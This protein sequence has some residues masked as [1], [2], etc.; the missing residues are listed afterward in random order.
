MSDT[1]KIRIYIG[2]GIV[3]STREIEIEED[4]GIWERM[5]EKERTDSCLEALFDS[6]IV[7]W[8]YE[9]KP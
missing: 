7:D 2:T 9:V 1:V 8:G 4:A 3:G 6:G 5:T